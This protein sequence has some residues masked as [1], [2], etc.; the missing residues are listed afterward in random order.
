MTRRSLVKTGPLDDAEPRRYSTAMKNRPSAAPFAGFA[1]ALIWGLTFLSIK[2]AVRELGPMTLALSRFIVA[3]A[4]LPLIA[5]VMR[6]S[7]KISLR[8]L[9]HL[10]AAGLVG[11]TLYFLCENNGVMLLSASEASIIVGTIPVVTL[12]AEV[13]FMRYR[14]G[15]RVWLGVILSFAGVAL[16]VLRSAGVAAS[17]LG[18]LYMAGA[19]LSWCAYSFLTRPLSGKYPMLVVTFWQIFFGM[20]G[21][22]PFALAEGPLAAFP[23]AVVSLNVLYLGVFGSAIGYWLYVIVLGEFGASR[24]SVF[25]N[26]IP[27]VSVVAAFILLGER[28]GPL[29]LAGGVIAV[30]GVYLATL[31]GTPKTT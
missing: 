8:D 22:I 30:A 31:T 12:I 27:V 16:M 13:L 3:S 24:S 15:L 11:V 23:S 14:P 5:L 7:L 28:L 10:A 6:Q 9:P 18:Y 29:Q 21:C 25:I 19:A 17:P 26:L 2:V 20:L 4:L 1:M